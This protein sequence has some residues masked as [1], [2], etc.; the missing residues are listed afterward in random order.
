MSYA[1]Q[2]D[3]AKALWDEGQKEEAKR[4][5]EEL[6]NQ[7]FYYARTPGPDLGMH[8]ALSA[9]KD[10][11][12][13]L[14]APNLKELITHVLA[15]TFDEEA[16]IAHIHIDKPEPQELYA[17]L[18]EHYPSALKT[19]IFVS[20]DKVETSFLVGLGRFFFSDRF[21]YDVKPVIDEQV[22]SQIRRTLKAGQRLEFEGEVVSKNDQFVSQLK[23]SET[24]KYS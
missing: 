7:G 16:P 23:E 20:S 2:I 9:W 21:Q 15:S 1:R 6:K 14:F 8:Y 24:Q 5:I 4:L 13:P 19:R 10:S 12:A 18:L 22:L 11:Y 17:L 3:Q